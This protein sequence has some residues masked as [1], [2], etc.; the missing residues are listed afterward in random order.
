MAR[1]KIFQQTIKHHNNAAAAI[2]ADTSCVPSI[3]LDL[4]AGANPTKQIAPEVKN[5]KLLR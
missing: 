2:F 1:H 3:L 5:A 4:N